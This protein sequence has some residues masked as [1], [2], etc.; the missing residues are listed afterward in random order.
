[1]GSR[2]IL[3]GCAELLRPCALSVF[4]SII[5]IP[6]T[7]CTGPAQGLRA[8]ARSEGGLPRLSMGSWQHT[9]QEA[10]RAQPSHVFVYSKLEVGS[11]YPRSCDAG[12]IAERSCIAG[13]TTAKRTCVAGTSW[14]RSCVAGSSTARRDCVGGTSWLDRAAALLA[15]LQLKREEEMKMD[16]L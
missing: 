8:A 11:F 1:M 4:I 3:G 6:P 10:V 2:T 9:L 5:I 13:T 15:L 14:K 16:P 12:T 7:L